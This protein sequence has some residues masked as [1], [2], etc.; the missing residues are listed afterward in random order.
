MRKRTTLLLK[1]FFRASLS[2]FFIFHTLA[3]SVL[4]TGDV[5]VSPNVNQSVS[6]TTKDT[7]GEITKEAVSDPESIVK[8]EEVAPYRKTKLAEATTKTRGGTY[9]IS[10]TSGIWTDVAGG[11]YVTGVNTSEVRWGKSDCMEYV[12]VWPFGHYENRCSGLGFNGTANQSFSANETFLLG[13]LTHFNWPVDDGA[14]GAK[15][16]ITLNFVNPALTPSPTFTYDFAIEETDNTNKLKNCKYYGTSNQISKTPC[17][18]IITFPKAYGQEVFTIGDIKYTLKIDG[19]TDSY[20]NGVAGNVINK[21]VTEEKKDNVAYLVGHLSS[22]LVEDPKISLIKK[23]NG[24]DANTPTGPIV[25]VGEMVDFEYIVQNTGNVALSGINVTD[26][27]D[28]SVTCPQTTLESGKSMT[29]TGRAV[30]VAGRYKNTGTVTTTSHPSVSASDVA[31]YYG[32]EKINICHATHVAS[33]QYSKEEVNMTPNVQGHNDHDGDIILPFSNDLVNYPGK[34]WD[35]YGQSIYNNDCKVPSGTLTVKKVVTPDSDTTSFNITGKGTISVA[36]APTFLDGDTGTIS[37]T[38]SKTFTVYPGTYSVTEQLSE[39]WRQVSNTCTNVVIAKGE[40]KECTITNTKEAKLTIVKIAYPG[41][42]QEFTF[43]SNIPENST[44]TLK[45]VDSSPDVN[46]SKTFNLTEGTYSVSEK[47]TDGWN[48]TSASCSNNDSVSAISLKPGDNV[49]CTFVNTKY[50]SISGHKWNDAD[51]LA[52]TADDRTAV[53]GWTIFIDKDSNAILDEGEISTTTGIDGKYSFTNLLPGTYTISEVLTVGW[54]QLGNLSQ[55]VTITAGEDK[56]NIDFIN[57]K[58]PTIQVIKNVDTDGDGTVDQT[59]VKDWQWLIDKDTYNTGSDP[60]QKIPG[61]YIVGER[62]KDNYHVVSLVCKNGNN[63]IVNTVAERKEITLQSGDNVVCTFTNARNLGK[64]IIEKEVVNDNGGSKKA[65]DFSFQIGSET[66]ISFAQNGENEL[67]GRNEYVRYAGL[68]YSITEVEANQNGYTTTYEHCTNI[69]VPHNGEVVCKI[70]NDDNKASLT[71][72]KEVKN[73]NGG[74]LV[75]TDW[76]LTATGPVTVIGDGSATSGNDFKA[77]TYTLSETGKPTV[78]VSGYKAGDWSC[79]DGVTVNENNQITLGLG[80]STTCTIVNDDIAPSLKLVKVVDNKYGGNAQATDWRLTATNGP[81]TLTGNG[82]VVS[83]DDFQ[84]GTYTLSEVGVVSG[85]EASSWSCTNGVTVNGNNEITLGLGQSTVCTI[86]NTEKQPT[87]T[88]VKTV[89]NTHGGTKEVSDF[90]LYIG[91]DKVTSGVANGVSSNVEYTV[92]EDQLAGYTASEWGGDCSADGKITLKSGENKT[93]TITNSDIAPTLKLVKKVINDNGG[94]LEQSNWTL[95]AKGDGGFDDTGDSTTFHTVKAGVEYILEESNLAG[96]ESKGWSCDGGTFNSQGAITLGLAENVTCTVTNDDIAPTLEIV[97]TVINDNGGNATV[98]TFNITLTDTTLEF[99]EGVP[100]PTVGNA[101]NYTAKPTVVAN[102]EYTLSEVVDGTGYSQDS[103]VCRIGNV[104]VNPTFTLKPGENAKCVIVNNDI[105]PGLTVKKHVKNDNGG[106]VNVSEFGIK[107]NNEDLAFETGVV[108][109]DTTTYT[110]TPSVVSNKE[111]TLSEVDHS[112]YTEGTWSCRDNKTQSEISHPFTLLEGQSVIC[113]ITNDDISPK[114]TV[115]KH[116]NNEGNDGLKQAS[117]FT[118]KVDGTNVSNTEFNG[119]EEGVTVTLNQGQFKVTEIEDTENYTATYEGCEGSINIGESKTC[120]ITNT[121]KDHKP[122]IGVTKIADKTSVDETGENVTF[123]FT[124]KNTSKVDTVE[125]LSLVD[126]VYGNL[127]GEHACKVGNTLAPDAEC[128]FTLTK[129]ISGNANGSSHKNTFT[130]TVKDEERNEVNNSDYE[131]ITFNNVDPTIE[132]TKTA[133]KA[134]VK[135]TGEDVTF[136]FTVKNTSKEE[137]TITSLTDSIFGNLAGSDSCKMGTSLAPNA[138]CSFTLTK[139]ISGDASGNP[140]KNTFT[141]EVKDD[142]GNEVSDNDDETITFTDVK[143]SIEVLK[144]ANISEVPETGGE[145][146][147]T[148]KV[149]NTGLEKVTIKS[150]KDNVI[151]TLNG[152]NDCKVGTELKA[153]ESCEFQQIFTIPSTTAGDENASTSHKNIF[154]AVVEDNEDNPAE[155]DDEEEIKLTPVPSLKLVKKVVHKYNSDENITEKDWILG[156]M[157]DNGEGFRYK[158]G[159]DEFRF[160]KADVEYSLSESG[161]YMNQFEASDWSCTGGELEGSTLTLSATDDVVCTITNTAKPATVTVDKKLRGYDDTEI[162]SDQKFSINLKNDSDNLI[163]NGEISSSKAIKFEGL[164]RGK[165]FVEEVNIP[166]GYIGEGCTP[167]KTEVD[168]GKELNFTCTNKILKPILDIEKTN[169]T[170][171]VPRYAGN[172]V[173]YTIKVSSPDD[174]SEGKY[175][176]K[177]VL[178]KDIAPAGFEYQSGSWTADSS[179]RGNIKGVEPIYNGIDVAEWSLGDMIE[180]EVITLTYSVRIS[181]TQDPGVYPDVAWAVG[182]SLMD[183]DVLTSPVGTEVEVIASNEIEEGDVLGIS[184]T[185]TQGR[186]LPNTGASTYLTLGAL[187]TIVFGMLFIFLKDE[188]KRKVALSGAFLAIATLLLPTAIFA[189]FPVVKIETPKSPTNSSNYNISFIA[190]HSDKKIKEVKCFEDGILVKSIPNVN[191]GNCEISGKTT[192][193]YKY[194]VSAVYEDDTSVSSNE[195]TVQVDLGKPSAVENYSKNGNVLKFRTAN[196][197]RTV[198][199][200]IFRANK[201]TFTANASTFIGEMPCAS[202]T[203]C[204]Y[205]DSTAVANQKY[206]YAI[207]AVDSFG[208]VSPFVSDAEEVVIPA[209]P[210]T[211][212]IAKTNT[213]TTVTVGNS[214]TSSSKESVQGATDS[215]GEVKGDETSTIK[216]EKKDNIKSEPKQTEKNSTESKGNVFKKFWY[217]WLSG[218]VIISGGVYAYVRSG[219]RD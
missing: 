119:S 93:C 66:P 117:D 128:S 126:S 148:F 91:N 86:T 11:S 219:K 168:N 121:G 30:A 206:Y 216:E 109:G 157:T 130:A 35:E 6:K 210:G 149:T 43:T 59:N 32:V 170:L 33:H 180:G 202:N 209:K 144:T 166:D 110:S 75:A 156:A 191:I 159:T 16:K 164:D 125:I 94:K 111:Y 95:T 96:Y 197:G 116:V 83:G 55:R 174:S 201:A 102:K 46:G 107:L 37:A 123:T 65:T 97:K 26:D 147:F 57:V 108:S 23:V 178:L 31:H 74:E 118:I 162:F 186:D 212:G 205:T 207:R 51:G 39:G 163:R 15:L 181:L 54:I 25:N 138:K 137:V 21:F 199:V 78:D 8:G 169:D 7:R 131:E 103:F 63:E 127:D 189:E 146:T 195:V 215:K 145:V 56:E 115:I 188:K 58:Y 176:L 29:C 182:K 62:Q 124:V 179:L 112:G 80:Q 50:G 167:G 72:V 175:I 34:N 185:H 76:E 53:S 143:P 151:G 99:G 40:S 213:T 81:V 204:A 106:N 105:A 154:T 38:Q 177:N 133:D 192:G 172:N 18:D 22:V 64:L 12:G 10:S 158:G 88:L 142:E 84:A 47:D 198:K 104:E 101:T 48:K 135:E 36:G 129:N 141:A 114:L 217:L 20:N 152:D 113:E 92:R 49:T 122:T 73:D 69:T 19:F 160:V 196:D 28:V 1:S 200:E 41:S 183:G 184:D 67:L 134:S 90:N 70:K 14:D 120:K 82:S 190:A 87:L 44:F 139:T 77:G 193:T 79:T 13:D 194:Y 5:L 52:T 100:L 218:F 17:D 9:T 85:Y 165:Y 140:H 42:E 155:D 153:G 161:E 68:S 208:S 150:L 211:T 60:V 132:V 71:L 2:L 171:G 98:D 187:L 45:D 136:T 173:T 3:P 61:K 89:S 27:K 203:E 4:A 24:D 214:T